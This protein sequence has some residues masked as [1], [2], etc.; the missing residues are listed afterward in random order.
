MENIHYKSIGEYLTDVGYPQ[1]EHPL[2]S[3]ISVNT[4]T[5]DSSTDC[6]DCQKTVTTDFYAISL[7]NIIEGEIL[8]G[9]T[10]YDCSNGT[11][12]FLAPNQKF[13]TQGIK[14]KSKGTLILIHPDYFVGNPL[15]DTI[16]HSDFFDYAVNEALHLSAKEE[17]LVAGIFES[18]S[19]EYQSHYDDC[20][21]EI[22]LSYIKT[23]L[24]YGQRFYKRQ[25]LQRRE[26][27]NSL[28]IKFTTQLEN[29]FANS[30]GNGLPILSDIADSMLLSSRYLSDAIKS[31]T[32]KSAKECMQQFI[33]DRA[34]AMLINTN[35]SITSLAYELGFDSPQYFVRLFKKKTD[36]TPTEF[37]GNFH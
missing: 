7:K 6:P 14:I 19:Q 28:F 10:H 18:I 20:S 24:T 21:R 1:P 34:K 31:E 35:T 2:F 12:I 13:S 32:G 25:F 3:I 37:R 29:H 9:K 23:L 17:K 26:L 4:D 15:S 30:A 27:N 22:I 33:I 5:S 16:K 8:Y 11:M 36:M